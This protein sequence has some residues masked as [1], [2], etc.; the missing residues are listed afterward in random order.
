MGVSVAIVSVCTSRILTIYFRNKVRYQSNPLDI[1]PAPSIIASHF[2]YDPTPNVQQPPLIKLDTSSFHS[3]FSISPRNQPLVGF[4][5]QSPVNSL[6]QAAPHTG[7]SVDFT[8]NPSSLDQRLPAQSYDSSYA[9]P[10]IISAISMEGDGSKSITSSERPET[11]AN[12][13]PSRKDVST[14]V[15]AC[16]QW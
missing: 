11:S 10:G 6:P 16:R 2:D 1:R 14:T 8:Y 5:P 13:R 15:I 3:D 12:S 4:V 9:P 7:L